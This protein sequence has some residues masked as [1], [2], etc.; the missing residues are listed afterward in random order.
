MPSFRL[1]GLSAKPFAHLSELTADELAA[2]GVLRVTAVSSPGYP[3]R[4]SLTDAQVGEE[5]FLLSY[6]HHPVD[7]P[8]RSSGPIYVRVHAEECRL[9]PGEVPPYVQTRLMSLRAYD[10]RHMM[11]GATVC[12]GE[13]VSAALER[14]FEQ[15][16]VRY[17]QLHNAKPGC[18]S[19]EARRVES[20]ASEA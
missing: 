13:E 19:C 12:P 4:V 16:E 9:A 11:V 2:H 17:V 8:Y 1:F 15:P 10:A 18:F 3:C 20:T 6:T 5:L 7:S 14:L